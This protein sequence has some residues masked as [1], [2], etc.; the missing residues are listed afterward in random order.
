MFTFH[1]YSIT[2]QYFSHNVD[3]VIKLKHEKELLFPAVTFCNMNPVKR[4]AIENLGIFL[5][6]DSN[7]QLRDKLKRHKRGKL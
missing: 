6:S 3:V 1:I 7:S 4:S 2:D 5:E